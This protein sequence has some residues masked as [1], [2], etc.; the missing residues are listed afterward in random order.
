[1]TISNAKTFIRRGMQEST[2]RDEVNRAS[3]AAALSALMERE[4]LVFSDHDFDE[5][6]HNLLVQCQERQQADQLREFKMWWDLTTAVLRTS[7]SRM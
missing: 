6:F 5:A 3:T 1:M 2:L 7:G 4:G